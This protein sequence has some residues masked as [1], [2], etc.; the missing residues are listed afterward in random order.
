MFSQGKADAQGAVIQTHCGRLS[1]FIDS[2][3]ILTGAKH[4]GYL[5]LMQ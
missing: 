2:K 4:Q 5:F 1:V 3:I